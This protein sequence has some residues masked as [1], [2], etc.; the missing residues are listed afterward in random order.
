[1]SFWTLPIS[2]RH[3]REVSEVLTK[4]F[5]DHPPEISFP[6]VYRVSGGDGRG[7][8]A[9]KDPAM[10]YVELPLGSDKYEMCCFACSLEGAVDDA[11]EYLRD[12]PDKEDKARD[13]CQKIAA[14]LHELAVKLEKSCELG[15]P[16]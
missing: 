15:Q 13:V 2:R 7:G 9:V 6:F 14:R 11:L 16:R 8:A 10:V 1:L 3:A 12:H 5:K 4:T